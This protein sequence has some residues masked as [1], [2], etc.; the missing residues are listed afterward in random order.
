MRSSQKIRRTLGCSAC[1]DGPVKPQMS[2]ITTTIILKRFIRN[3]GDVGLM[4]G[5]GG[6][7]F[8]PTE[9]ELEATLSTNIL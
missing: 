3:M 1:R 2:P 9:A 6:L 5:V 7:L 8:D 4:N